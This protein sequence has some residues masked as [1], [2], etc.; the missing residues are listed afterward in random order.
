[1]S[2]ELEHLKQANKDLKEQIND[3][4]KRLGEVAGKLPLA[5][6]MGKL[7]GF[8]EAKE[9]FQQLAGEG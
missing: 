7:Q 6:A 2:E 8:K 4:E 9:L 1:M 5:R 3:L